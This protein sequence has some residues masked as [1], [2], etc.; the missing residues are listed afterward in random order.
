MRLAFY[1]ND[2]DENKK[3]ESGECDLK[4]MKRDFPSR[5]L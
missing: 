1:K 4:I 2:D 5:G 3:S